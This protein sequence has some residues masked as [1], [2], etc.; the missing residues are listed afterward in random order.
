MID[1]RDY[2]NS[3]ST[4]MAGD[5]AHRWLLETQLQACF[6]EGAYQEEER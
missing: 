1:V 2:R 3:M 6:E 5:D 4:R